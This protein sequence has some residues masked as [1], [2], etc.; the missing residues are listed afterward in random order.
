VATLEEEVAQA[1]TDVTGS[2]DNQDRRQLVG[3]VI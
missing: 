1:G 2:T 3:F